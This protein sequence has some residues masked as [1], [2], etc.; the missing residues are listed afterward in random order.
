MS[1]NLFGP[2]N[3]TNAFLPHMRAR[4][5]GTILFLG[6]RTTWRDRLPLNGYYA[7]AKAG[8][9]SISQAYAAELASFNVRTLLIE[10]GGMQT[11]NWNNIIKADSLGFA[12]DAEVPPSIVPPSTSPSFTTPNGIAT[13]PIKNLSAYTELKRRA[14]AFM[15]DQRDSQPSS[16]IK[17]AR[18]LAD[19]VRGEGVAFNSQGKLRPW[20]EWLMLGEDVDSD[21]RE[22]CKRTIELLDEWRDV[23]LGV[24]V[25][26]GEGRR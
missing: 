5:K 12:S 3:V 22:K 4:K 10:P 7:A 18:V 2:I 19:L 8:L 23:V 24:G 17:I 9:R 26:P 14:Y 15:D 16:A 6:S 25:D 1:T 21:V 11:Q 20:P 13:A